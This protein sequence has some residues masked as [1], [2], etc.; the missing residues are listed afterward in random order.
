VAAIVPLADPSVPPH[1]TCYVSVEDADAA[2]ARAHE[3]G[4]T[5]VPDP[6]E[7]PVLTLADPE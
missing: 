1:W 7:P 3:L 4:A 6:A 2:A 5:V